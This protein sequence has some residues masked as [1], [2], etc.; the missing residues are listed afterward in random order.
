M[1]KDHH[2]TF[3]S[4]TLFALEYFAYAGTYLPPFAVQILTGWRCWCFPPSP[5]F[6]VGGEGGLENERRGGAKEARERHSEQAYWLVPSSSVDCDKFNCANPLK[7]DASPDY[8]PPHPPT[9]A[10]T[11]TNSPSPLSFSAVCS[12][13]VRSDITCLLP[14]ER[15]EVCAAWGCMSEDLQ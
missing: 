7:A 1:T 13:S 12:R 6:S 9:L 3:M 15:F 8:P 14:T 5:F 10:L 4:M 11:L 2:M